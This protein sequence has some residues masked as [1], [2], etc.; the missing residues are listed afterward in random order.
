M[1]LA[2][3]SAVKELQAG[4]DWLIGEILSFRGEAAVLEPT[5]LRKRVATRAKELARELN[6]SRVTA[7]A[8]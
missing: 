2:D 4:D 8:T 7:A 6:V 1:P 3:G 5:A